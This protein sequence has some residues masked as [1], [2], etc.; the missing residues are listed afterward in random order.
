M[1]SSSWGEESW[2]LV[3]FL[4]ACVVAMFTAFFCSGHSLLS[5]GPFVVC[6]ALQ[7]E[8]ASRAKCLALKKRQREAG[9][10][11][12]IRLQL[13][14]NPESSQLEPPNGLCSGRARKSAIFS[15]QVKSE[16]HLITNCNLRASSPP[17]CLEPFAQDS[18]AQ[19][20][21]PHRDSPRFA[22]RSPVLRRCARPWPQMIPT[23]ASLAASTAEEQ[24]SGAADQASIHG[25]LAHLFKLPLSSHQA[26]VM[27]KSLVLEAQ[28]RRK[29]RRLGYRAHQDGI[30][31]RR[32]RRKFPQPL[33][34]CVC[35]K[36]VV[37][38]ELRGVACHE[39][40]RWS[41]ALSRGAKAR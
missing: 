35:A 29:R 28:T 33:H 36:E 39:A 34:G 5:L 8:A 3:W 1:R 37:E 11:E 19:S 16:R 40:C 22:R 32:K 7:G 25:R 41:S 9:R 23:S 30:I 10:R 14:R 6:C 26:I 18:K 38:F 2:R 24:P 15:R 17:P 27:R 21:T 31:K 13:I 20:Q 12:A 4:F